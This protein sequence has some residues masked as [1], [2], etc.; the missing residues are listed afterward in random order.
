M[1]KTARQTLAA[2]LKTANPAQMDLILRLQILEGISGLQPNQAVKAAGKSTTACVAAIKDLA[3]KISPT[4]SPAWWATNTA[5]IYRAAVAGI[6]SIKQHEV[7]PDEIL[8][9]MI[10]GIGKKENQ[11]MVPFHFIGHEFRKHAKEM[12]M[13][14]NGTLDPDYGTILNIAKSYSRR[15]AM[16]IAT[17]LRNRQVSTDPDDAEGEV[18]DASDSNR[19]EDIAIRLESILEEPNAPGNASVYKWLKEQ[20]GRVG[21]PVQQ[22]LMQRYVDLLEKDGESGALTKLSKESGVSMPRLSLVKKVM[23]GQIAKEMEES[24]SNDAMWEKKFFEDLERG[25]PMYAR[26]KRALLRAGT[27][28]PMLRPAVVQILKG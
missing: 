2:V 12:D 17:A 5:A 1:D 14:A 20:F 11:V 25:R 21:T 19:T 8:H 22:K 9:E 13:L 26:L 10:M 3:L 15:K 27:V 16:D 23:L 6:Q 24:G 4:V 7:S 28:N 18:S